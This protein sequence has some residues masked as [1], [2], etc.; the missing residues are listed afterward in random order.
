MTHA[1]I[2]NRNNINK[3]NNSENISRWPSQISQ[4]WFYLIDRSSQI[5]HFISSH[6]TKQQ[7]DTEQN[8][9]HF[10]QTNQQ[11]QTNKYKSENDGRGCMLSCCCYAD[12]LQKLS[13]RE[14]EIRVNAIITYYIYIYNDKPTNTFREDNKY[15]IISQYNLF[16]IRLNDN[17]NNVIYYVWLWIHSYKYIYYTLK[18]KWI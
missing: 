11:R 4:N 12:E 3:I 18:H 17:K 7:Y 16:D 8:T 2:G 5:H 6:R 14:V 9:I 1:R 13:L 15:T 10:A